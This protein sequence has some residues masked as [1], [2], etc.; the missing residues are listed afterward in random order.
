MC[1]VDGHIDVFPCLNFQ[2]LIISRERNIS[3]RLRER[4]LSNMS[5]SDVRDSLEIQNGFD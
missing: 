1:K 5:V 4:P 2:Y 3:L